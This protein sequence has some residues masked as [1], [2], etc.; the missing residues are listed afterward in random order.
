M[1]LRISAS[2]RR[3]V[4]LASLTTGTRRHCGAI[5]RPEDLVHLASCVCVVAHLAVL[6]SDVCRVNKS[7]AMR[8]EVNGRADPRYTA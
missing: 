2:L 1:R 6:A 5:Q 8:Y 7:F 3:H 4:S